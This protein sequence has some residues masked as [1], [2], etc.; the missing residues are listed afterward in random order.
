VFCP[1]CRAEYR[2]GFTECSD[3]RVPLIAEKPAT[4]GDPGLE[5]VTVLES[6]DALVVTSAKTL[7]EDAGIPF[8]VLG[9]E[10]APRIL[11]LLPWYRI[12]IGRDH[13]TKAI[14]LLRP[15]TEAN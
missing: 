12:Q 9:D 15:L 10:V 4:A 11:G 1:Q 8:W 2:E 14:A 7:L 6:G 3:C 5:L 13:E